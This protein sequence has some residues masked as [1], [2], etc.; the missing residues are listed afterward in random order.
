MHALGTY[1]DEAVMEMEADEP[2]GDAGVLGKGRRDGLPDKRLGVGAGLLVEP[3]LELGAGQRRQ[4]A[5]HRGE[6]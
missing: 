2:G 5:Q 3:D 6:G 4:Q 1:P